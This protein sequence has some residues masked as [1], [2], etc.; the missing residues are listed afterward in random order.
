MPNEVHRAVGQ[1]P[2]LCIHYVTPL[3]LAWLE[4]ELGAAKSGERDANEVG[5][6]LSQLLAKADYEN[7]RERRPRRAPTR[8]TAF[9]DFFD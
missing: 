2:Q 8:T 3:Q 7:G 1:C 6:L 5:A 4:Q 9:V